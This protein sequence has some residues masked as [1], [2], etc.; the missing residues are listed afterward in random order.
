MRSLPP[1]VCA[2]QA[3]L[4]ASRAAAS[5]AVGT[6]TT[7]SLWPAGH[8]EPITQRPTRKNC[9]QECSPIS[10]C[11]LATHGAR[12]QQQKGCKPFDICQPPSLQAVA[13][14]VHVSW[15]QLGS[16]TCNEVQCIQQARLQLL[17]LLEV[18]ALVQHA[19]R[20]K[21]S[22]STGLQQDNLSL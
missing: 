17:P 22:A 8:P 9:W 1:H 14:V 19:A 2:F 21:L 6:R 3:W 15:Q 13:A 5:F 18:E 16:P 7:C 20:W 12:P 4:H 11:S 10:A